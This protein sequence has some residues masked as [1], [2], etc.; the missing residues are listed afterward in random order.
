MNAVQE[1]MANVMQD[2][3]PCIGMWKQHNCPVCVQRGQSRPDTRGRG[4]HLFSSDG[5]VAYNCFNCHAKAV[6]APGSKISENMNQILEAF[7]ITNKDKLH[8]L[9]I[10]EE[11]INSGEYA[12]DEDDESVYQSKLF[13]R[14]MKRDLPE[15]AKRFTEWVNE[16]NI[17]EQ[18]IKV[19]NA[20]NDRNPYLLDLELY[21]TPLRKNYLHERFIVPYYMNSEIVGYTARHIN[22]DSD[23][24]YFNQVSTQILYN[25]DLLNDDKMKIILTSEGP[26]DAA[27]MG[28]IA[29]NNY[30]LSTEQIKILKS[31]QERGKKIVIVPDRDKNGMDAIKQAIDNGFSVSLPEYGVIRDSNGIRYIKDFEEATVHYGR[32]FALK[33]VYDSI[34]D[35]PFEIGVYGNKW[36]Y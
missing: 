7:G 12:H 16:P 34:Y 18:F 3:A 21:W 26:L 10:T 25:F 8:L 17:P 23:F 33:L 5:S 27:L 19:L 36:I 20:V 32:L 22:K 29:T 11:M 9:V 15:G 14:I 2:Y 6:W 13:Q 24:R 28:G 1:I 30:F 35:T 31:A 4:N